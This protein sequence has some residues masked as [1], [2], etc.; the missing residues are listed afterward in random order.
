MYLDAA[1]TNIKWEDEAYKHTS[2]NALGGLLVHTCFFDIK[3]K[4]FTQDPYFMVIVLPSTG[5]DDPVL[6]LTPE[7]V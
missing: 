3:K 2:R 1:T 4:A 7:K 6:T 5:L